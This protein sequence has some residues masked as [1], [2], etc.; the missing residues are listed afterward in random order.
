MKSIK[1]SKLITSVL[2]IIAVMFSAISPLAGLLVRADEYVHPDNMLYIVSPNSGPLKQRTEVVPGA[3]YN[4]SF[5]IANNAPEF[6]VIGQDK[7]RNSIVI[8]PQ[9][10]AKTVIGDYTLY[11]YLITIPTDIPVQSKK[12]R[13]FVGLSFAAESDIYVF[14]FSLV[15]SDDG[16]NKNVLSNGKFVTNLND[17]AWGNSVWFTT[18]QT[19]GKNKTEWEDEN[20][21]MRIMTFDESKFSNA[22]MLYYKSGNKGPL[23]TRVNFTSGAAYNIYFGLTNNI[24]SFDI[25]GKTDETRNKIAI[26]ETLVSKED[27]GSYTLYKYTFI[28]PS[29]VEDGLAFIGISFPANSEAYVFDIKLALGED[30]EQNQILSNGGFKSGLD[31]WAWDWDAWFE[32]YPG[33]QGK[34]KTE[35]SNTNVQLK[36][37]T[38]DESLFTLETPLPENDQMLYFKS[39]NV[40]PLMQRVNMKSGASYNISFALTYNITTFDI[41][42]KTDGDRSGISIAETLVSKETKGKYIVYN[43]TFTFPS[44]KEDGLAFIGITFPSN[45]EGYIFDFKMTRV[46]DEE[47]KDVISNGDFKYGLNHWAWDW[48]GWFESWGNGLG[49]YEFEGENLLLQVMDFD[50]NKFTLEPP[51][52]PKEQMLY[53]NSSNN[54]PLLYRANFKAG[55]EY[56]ITFGMSD[57]LTGFDIVGKTDGDRNSISIDETLISREEKGTYSFYKYSFTFPSDKEDGLAFIGITFPLSH[58]GYIFGVKLWRADDESEKQLMSNGG[59]ASGLDHWAW[60][61]AAWFE[62]WDK[63]VGKTEWSNSNV[64]LATMDFDESKFT[65]PIPEPPKDQ[66]LYYK[67]NNTGPLMTRVNLTPGQKYYFSYYVSMNAVGTKVVAQTDGD[68]KNISINAKQIANERADRH[69]FVKWEFTVPDT[70]KVDQGKTTGLAFV[71]VKFVLGYDGYFYKAKLWKADDE[72]EKQLFSNGDFSSKLDHW[73][74]DWDAWFEDYPG[75]QGKGQTE[76]SNN[77]VTLNLM[78]FDESQFSIDIPDIPVSDRRM[79]QFKN[80]ANPTPFSARVNV[81]QNKTFILSYSVFCTD[82]TALSVL[83]DDDRYVIKAEEELLDE[84]ENSQYKT[85]KYKFTIPD[86]YDS[87]FAF[88]GIDIPYY[89]EGYLF[90]LSCYAADDPNQKSVWQN[91]GFMSDLDSWIWGWHAWFGM[92]TSENS[93]L[94]PTGMYKWTNGIDEIKII[95]FDLSLIDALIADINRD[96]GVWWSAGDYSESEAAA[97]EEARNAPGIARFKGTFIADGENNVENVKMVLKSETRTYFATTDK[98]GRFSFGNVIED[99]YELFFVNAEGEEVSSGF[100]GYLEA[101]DSVSIALASDTSIIAEN[102]AKERIEYFDGA[103][104]TPKLTPVA[105][106]TVYLRNF[107]SV[108]TDNKGHFEFSDIPAGDY[109]VYTVLPNGEEYVFRTVTLQKN[110]KLSVK[111]KYDAPSNTSQSGT[112]FFTKNRIILISCIA[113]GI[114]LV[115]A[116]AV[117]L[118]IIRKKKKSVK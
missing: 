116:G 33:C 23:M 7:D 12:Y 71:G 112:G 67:N 31:H 20:V 89:A 13:V 109:E 14:D 25:V 37:V 118:I 47:N 105:G 101:G 11:N 41:V 117:V 49:L 95:D 102:A 111:L 38:F 45:S 100:F 69:T 3:Q 6:T 88:V 50:V 96:D 93:Y 66:M 18:G 8:N 60:D 15:K 24:K 57:N 81:T 82:D 106:L 54:G 107:G 79:L 115:A 28:F 77:N 4:F 42:G 86:N 53:F 39:K 56:Y 43:Y 21:T 97:A 32:D 40:G 16:S 30:E 59:F 46:G 19:G 29:T 58:E 103:V 52:P 76:F 9:Q 94:K 113:G 2:L 65:L 70:F 35:W 99:S 92:G 27:M 84:T 48:D 26:D 110:Q 80:G 64:Q 73:A 72:T 98:L 55:A 17:W 85:Y 78:D 62:T 87:T 63:G 22:K 108:K 44:N 104:Y 34:G 10:T 91:P 75:W 1:Q 61:W 36:T 51:E 90:D 83:T 74:W 68:H 5:G 114:L